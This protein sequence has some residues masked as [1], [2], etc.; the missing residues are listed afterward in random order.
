MKTTALITHDNCSDGFLSRSIASKFFNNSKIEFESYSAAYPWSLP[1]D[2]TNKHD[3]VYIIDFSLS[4]EDFLKL[5][6]NNI[7]VIWIDHHISAIERTKD[8][9]VITGFKGI[10]KDGIAGS[11]LAWDYFFPWKINE[12]PLVVKH[13]AIR[14]V[15]GD[16]PG[17]GNIPEEAKDFDCGLRTFAKNEKTLWD[18]LMESNEFTEE[19]CKIG[20]LTRNMDKT[21][22]QI[23]MNDSRK[24]FTGSFND[25]DTVFL[26]A[27]YPEGEQADLVADKF[28]HHLQIWNSIINI[29]GKLHVNI[30]FRAR[31]PEIDCSVMAQIFGGGG[32]KGAGGAIVSL[33]EFQKQIVLDKIAE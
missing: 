25:C 21:K 5:H 4:N 10:R 32:H 26:S 1:E 33:E 15:W 22:I 30:S 31:S 8:N 13:V 7:D 23:L 17:S 24:C 19:V 28:P 6:T 14:D 2:F 20:K 18:Q 9:P 16:P 12:T 29:D 11:K 3:V 27:T